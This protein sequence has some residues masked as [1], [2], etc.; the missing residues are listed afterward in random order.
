[1]LC[2]LY[3]NEVVYIGV[4]ISDYNKGSG[5]GSR[6]SNYWTYDS[7]NNGVRTYNPTI[8]GVD[9]IITLPFSKESFYLAAALE[10]YLIKHLQ[11]P[12]NRTHSK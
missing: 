11:T 6:I 2:H 7:S 12:R 1:M 5:L 4:A 8:E 10:V 3:K 9:S